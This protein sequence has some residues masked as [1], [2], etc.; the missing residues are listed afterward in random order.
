MP[1]PYSGSIHIKTILSKALFNQLHI[2]L[3]FFFLLGKGRVM[4]RYSLVTFFCFATFIRFSLYIFGR[5]T[6]TVLYPSELFLLPTHPGQRGSLAASNLR[7]LLKSSI[8]IALN[9]QRL[10]GKRGPPYT[11]IACFIQT[12]C[13]QMPFISPGY[14]KA[15]DS[16]WL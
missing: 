2:F 14:R 10:L 11:L 6:I 1:K 3:I 4:D 5:Q 8:V 7:L 15:S 16:G 13:I 12:Q 9:S